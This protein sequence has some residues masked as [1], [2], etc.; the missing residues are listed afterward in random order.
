MTVCFERNHWT[1]G[2]TGVTNFHQKD[3]E[4]YQKA[5]SL[6]NGNE[7]WIEFYPMAP[8]NRKEIYSLHFHCQ[9]GKNLGEFWRIFERIKNKDEGKE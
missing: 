8:E 6:Y 2:G 7:M 5:I 9:P 4:I 3:L 1:N